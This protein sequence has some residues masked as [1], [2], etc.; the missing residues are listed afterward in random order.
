M[1][2]TDVGTGNS[3][4]YET[5]IEDPAPGP[6]KIR[7]I[8]MHMKDNP[9]WLEDPLLD[10]SL[11]VGDEIE[12]RHPIKKGQLIGYVGNSGNCTNKPTGGHHLHFE[13]YN[14]TENVPASSREAMKHRINPTYFY[15]HLD[16]DVN[17]SCDL[18]LIPEIVG[19][20]GAARKEALLNW[21]IDEK[22]KK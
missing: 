21:D 8:V 9:V 18:S 15:P 11:T 7:V 20:T 4:A 17:M 12:E 5:N 6:N 2:R 19:L 22:Y 10:K 16:L 14:N 1:H 3:I 13:V